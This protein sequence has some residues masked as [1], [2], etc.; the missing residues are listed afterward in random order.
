M[1]I[2]STGGH[3]LFDVSIDFCSEPFELAHFD[4]EKLCHTGGEK[5]ALLLWPVEWKLNAQIAEIRS[6]GHQ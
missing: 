2:A 4:T 3:N 6:G 5:V 1:S